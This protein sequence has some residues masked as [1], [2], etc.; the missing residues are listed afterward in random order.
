MFTGRFNVVEQRIINEKHLKMSLSHDDSDLTIIDA[1]AFTPDAEL[2][3]C[4]YD[5]INA[6]FRL[7]LNEYRGR[8]NIQ[9]IIEKF[10][11]GN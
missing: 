3:T 9:M 2:L 10:Y 4:E 7:D 6:T 1:I 5:A 8:C 11:K